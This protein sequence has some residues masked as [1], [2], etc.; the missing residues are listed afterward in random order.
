[1]RCPLRSVLAAPL[2]ALLFVATS[3]RAQ[4]AGEG[5]EG[6][7]DEARAAL[8]R[9][10]YDK[11]VRLATLPATAPAAQRAEALE[12]VAVAE[13]SAGRVEPGRKAAAELFELAP[14][15]EPDEVQLP[16]AAQ[17]VFREE[18]SKPRARRVTLRFET[19]ASDAA[20]SVR[21]VADRDVAEARVAC[22]GPSGKTFVPQRVPAGP[23]ASFAVRLGSSRT[24][25]CYAIAVG[26]DGALVG[27][28]GSRSRP[29]DVTATGP[30][31]GAST[32]PQEV[33]PPSPSTPVLKSWWFWT[34][35]GT[36]V[37]A[38]AVTVVVV[39]TAGSSGDK[40]SETVGTHSGTL[41]S[42]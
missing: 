16:A 19:S 7:L 3:A 35:V 24:Q 2:S 30:H 38:G 12:I 36:A 34:A 17:G 42:W 5:A 40:P 18:A 26:A 37:L 13:L 20:Y 41:L 29:V 27:R 9:N 22:L 4:S 28:L 6:K 39:A 15:F 1:M 25:H 33:P 21:L 31:A 10:D 14:G 8:A 23:A 11:A 32:A